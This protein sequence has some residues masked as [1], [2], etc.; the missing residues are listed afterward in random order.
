MKIGSVIRFLFQEIMRLIGAYG[1]DD[2]DSRSGS[3]Y[4]FH[5][6]GTDWEEQAKLLAS[7]GE[8]FDNFGYTT[9]ISGNYAADWCWF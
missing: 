9:S 8:Q 6:N 1:D 7:D 5:K 3:A 4:V 2:N